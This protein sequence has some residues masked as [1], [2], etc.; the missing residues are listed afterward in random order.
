[1]QSLAD[2]ILNV[3]VPKGAIT[4]WWLGQ[5]GF[6]FK[7]SGNKVVVVDPYLSDAAE[8]LHGFKRLAVTPIEAE[9]VCADWVVL[10][11]EHTDHLDPD[12][13]PI[14]TKNNPECRFAAPSGCIDGFAQAGVAPDRQTIFQPH[15]AYDLGGIVVHTALAEHCG[16]APTAL[17][18]LFD[19]DGVRV[20]LTGDTAFSP[21]LLQP[22]A[23]MRPDVFV[24]AIN[25]GFGNINHIDAARMTAQVKPRY[26]IPCH[27]WTFAEQG[28]GDPFGFLQACSYFCPEVTALLLKPGEPFTITDETPRDGANN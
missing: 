1:M 10:T 26:A 23:D 15:A 3:V 17:S 9:D 16:N 8:R 13:L 5:A 12:A 6:A 27:Y 4:I 28:A 7:T 21:L 14:I 11:H 24:P 19:F 20:L 25:G 2:N 18:L 22:L